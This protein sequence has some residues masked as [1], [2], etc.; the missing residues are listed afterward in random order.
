MRRREL[1]ALFIKRLGP[2]HHKDTPLLI[3]ADG[4]RFLCPKCYNDPPRVPI[5]THSV[6][7]WFVGHVPDSETPGPGRWTPSGTTLDNLTFVPGKPP[8]ACS[9]LL[10]A[11]CNWHGFVRN[12]DAT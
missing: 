3:W 12:G 1:Q 6:I 2:G 9:V 7:C 11:G 8:R 10:T 4:I 5:G